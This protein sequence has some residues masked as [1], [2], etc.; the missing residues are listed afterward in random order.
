MNKNV[1][2]I[3]NTNNILKLAVLTIPLFINKNVHEF[4]VN[5]EMLLKLLLII[6]LTLWA[7]E[8]L[9]KKKFIY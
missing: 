1:F 8:T 7:I 5:Q 9:N 3:I 4:R 6:A 2:Q